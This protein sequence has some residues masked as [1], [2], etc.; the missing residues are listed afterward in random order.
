MSIMENGERLV[1]QSPLQAYPKAY[2]I[3]V[4]EGP[5]PLLLE[6]KNE[7]LVLF[8]SKNSLI[9]LK[10]KLPSKD[11]IADEVLVSGQLIRIALEVDVKR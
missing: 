10:E 11:G 9:E 3:D 7:N 1:L 8:V 5:K 2:V 4:Y 6:E